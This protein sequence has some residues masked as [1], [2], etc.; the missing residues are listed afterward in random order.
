MFFF[1]FGRRVLIRSPVDLHTTR[2]QEDQSNAPATISDL[3]D[4][5]YTRR[6]GGIEMSRETRRNIKEL[7]ID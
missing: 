6:A 3:F 2:Q 5:M 1:F 7:A 4:R